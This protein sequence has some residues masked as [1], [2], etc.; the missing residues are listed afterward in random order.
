MICWRFQTAVAPDSFFLSRFQGWDRLVFLGTGQ[1]VRPA[2]HSRQAASATGKSDPSRYFRRE[3]QAGLVFS[4][5]RRQN[6]LSAAARESHSQ[7]WRC[8][9]RPP[10]PLTQ[11]AVTIN[12]LKMSYPPKMPNL[13]FYCGK[14]G[15]VSFQKAPVTDKLKAK[16]PPNQR[17]PIPIDQR[18]CGVPAP[19]FHRPTPSSRRPERSAPHDR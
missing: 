10:A 5:T 2:H 18:I 19:F 13:F 15:L 14:I 4:R 8:Q 12:F 7:T 3:R 17:S 11:N 1:I 9:T 6:S 16:R